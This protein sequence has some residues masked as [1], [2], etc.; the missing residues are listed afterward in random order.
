MEGLDFF[1]CDSTEE[2]S[3]QPSAS[4]SVSAF[5]EFIHKP[6]L[7]DKNI[8]DIVRSK[9]A[10]SRSSLVNQARINDLII[11][12]AGSTRIAVCVLMLLFM[13][14]KYIKKRKN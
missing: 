8:K 7:P 3:M 10:D 11:I 1:E 4:A 14:Y 2:Q 9:L 12:V 13:L 5:V 6:D